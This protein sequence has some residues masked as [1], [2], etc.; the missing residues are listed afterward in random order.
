MNNKEVTVR[1]MSASTLLGIAFIILKLCGVIQ[2][3]WW[4][5]LAPFWIPFVLLII[6]LLIAIAYT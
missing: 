4:W 2:W 1:G 6:L 5:V 3:S